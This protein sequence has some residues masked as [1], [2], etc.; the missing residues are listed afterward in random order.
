MAVHWCQGY[1][2]DQPFRMDCMQD[3]FRKMVELYGIQFMVE[4]E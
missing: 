1:W 3:S 2:Y 4:V